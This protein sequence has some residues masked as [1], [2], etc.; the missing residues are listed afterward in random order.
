MQRLPRCHM[1]LKS[2]G[3]GVPADLPKQGNSTA[4]QPIREWESIPSTESQRSLHREYE[5]GSTPPGI[6]SV[7]CQDTEQKGFYFPEKLIHLRE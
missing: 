2:L 7:H 4:F 3:H 1:S 5:L 6:P